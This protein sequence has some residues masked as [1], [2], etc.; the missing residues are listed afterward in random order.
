MKL[1]IYELFGQWNKIRLFKKNDKLFE[2]KYLNQLLC[3]LNKNQQ[4]I[5]IFKNKL[6][7]NVFQIV[8]FSS[9]LNK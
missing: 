6:K 2:Q 9:E 5:N 8:Y 1:I 7:K 4:N 3:L